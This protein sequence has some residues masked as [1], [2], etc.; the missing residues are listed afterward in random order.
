MH[1][2]RFLAILM[3]PLATSK[4]LDEETFGPAF[5]STIKD[6]TADLVV[7]NPLKSNAKNG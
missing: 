3:R 4:A 5:K 1:S 2:Q 6:A 7:F